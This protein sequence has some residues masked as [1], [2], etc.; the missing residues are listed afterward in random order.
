MFGHQEFEGGESM[1]THIK[2]G[3]LHIS[4][5]RKHQVGLKHQFRQR[6]AHDAA[7]E[8]GVA[9]EYGGHIFVVVSRD[10]KFKN[11]RSHANI[12][13]ALITTLLQTKFKDSS[14]R[15]SSLKLQR[16]HHLQQPSQQIVFKNERG[17]FL[18]IFLVRFFCC[19]AIGRFSIQ[20]CN[21]RFEFSHNS[22]F[23]GRR[24]S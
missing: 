21:H 15:F 22:E 1:R 20:E 11:L 13:D 23:R 16:F 19:D 7:S 3:Q 6:P 24:R 18:N 9:A 4:E 8:Y 10:E 2:V 12:R 5:K 17:H 14:E